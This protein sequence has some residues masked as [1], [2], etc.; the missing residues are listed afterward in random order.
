MNGYKYTKIIRAYK[1][2]LSLSLSLF[3]Y[4]SLSIIFL[5]NSFYLIEFYHLFFSANFTKRCWSN[6]TW[7]TSKLDVDGVHILMNYSACKAAS[8]DKVGSVLVYDAFFFTGLKQ[9][10]KTFISVYTWWLYMYITKLT[11]IHKMPL[12]TNATLIVVNPRI[13][14]VCW[15]VWKRHVW[16]AE[17]AK[18]TTLQNQCKL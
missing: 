3:L 16:A 2:S 11:R 13:N 9:E 14:S 6:G 18:M 15:L 17:R 4:F 1:L 12:I 8:K 7:D 5:F 10:M